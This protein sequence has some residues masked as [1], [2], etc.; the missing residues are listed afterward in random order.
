MGHMTEFRRRAALVTVLSTI[1][2][3]SLPASA[4]DLEG[5]EKMLRSKFTLVFLF[6]THRPKLAAKGEGLLQ[7]ENEIRGA[8]AAARDNPAFTNIFLDLQLEWGRLLLGRGDIASA[9]SRFEVIFKAGDNARGFTEA[10]QLAADVYESQAD[11]FV[12]AGDD[13]A[14]LAKYARAEDLC[15]RA[16]NS[17]RALAIARKTT[18]VICIH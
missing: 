18:D 9:L 15:E 6:E 3:L 11:E 5:A 4:Q 7:L 12:K 17:E 1:L 13:A 8:L 10:A 14:A 2:L 16:G